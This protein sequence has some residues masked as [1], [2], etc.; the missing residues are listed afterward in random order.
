MYLII[1]A[2]GQ[3]TRLRP[4][5]DTIPKCLVEING[6]AILDWQLQ[7]IRKVGITDIAVVR[8]Y[9]KDTIDRNDILFFENPLFDS[10]NMVETLWCAESIFGD[11]FIMSYGDIIYEPS[12]LDSLLAAKQSVNV[13][14]DM[15]WQMYWERRFENVL[16]DAETLQ[17]DSTG[18][19]TSI[20][21]KPK[22]INEI[23]A[24]YIGLM[25]FKGEGVDA[26]RSVYAQAQ[27]EAAQGR[28]PLR[29]QRPLNKL[30]MTD[31][32]QGIIDS[33]FPIHGVPVRRGWLEIDSLK[34]LEIAN[35]SIHPVKEGFRI[36]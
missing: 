34:D 31:M 7:A 6:R 36:R 32:L 30:Y 22:S 3:G 33:G 24:Q 8:G 23:G 20:G 18:R 2:A 10:T 21:Q 5:T 14:V 1:L 9:K 17:F 15:D 27:Y 25:S 12:V 28:N 4:L 19:I 29:G 13:I 11:G 35:Q 16:D 26:W